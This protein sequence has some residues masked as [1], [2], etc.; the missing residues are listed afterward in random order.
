MTATIRPSA[1]RHAY[2]LRWIVAH[3]IEE[4]ARHV[5]RADIL[6]QQIDGATGK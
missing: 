6:R 2:T 1:D 4:T 5:G 3:M